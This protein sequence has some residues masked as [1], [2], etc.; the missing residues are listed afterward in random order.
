VKS[1]QKNDEF[2][3]WRFNLSQDLHV[4]DEDEQFCKQCQC[5][6]FILKTHVLGEN[7]KYETRIHTECICFNCKLSHPNFKP[8]YEVKK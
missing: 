3:A 8:D 6:T 5:D 4:H 1:W 7:D 2:A